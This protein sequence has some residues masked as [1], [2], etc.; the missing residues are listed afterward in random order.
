MARDT[1]GE[2]YKL[3]RALL[4][5]LFATWTG[6]TEKLNTNAKERKATAHFSRMA[7]RSARRAV[8]KP[9]LMTALTTSADDAPPVE[10]TLSPDATETSAHSSPVAPID[11]PASWHL[12]AVAAIASLANQVQQT[13]PNAA[14]AL[15]KAAESLHSI[16]THE[17][18]VDSREVLDVMVASLRVSITRLVF[19]EEGI[20]RFPFFLMP[21]FSSLPLHPL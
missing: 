20:D 14:K 21:F 8:T 13:S 11:A 19:R 16:L 6:S 18:G 5:T 3:F 4:V 17:R 9:V 2:G 10:L 7:G 12:D 15:S 1:Q